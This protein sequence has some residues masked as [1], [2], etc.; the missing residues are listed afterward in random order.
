MATLCEGAGGLTEMR[1]L[2]D[3]V[4]DLCR[5]S[6]VGLRPRSGGIVLRHVGDLEVL[7]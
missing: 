2:L 6:L 4:Q 5:E 7:R 1:R 3:Q